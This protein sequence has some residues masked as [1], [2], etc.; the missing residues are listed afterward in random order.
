MLVSTSATVPEAETASG[1]AKVIRKKQTRY[2]WHVVISVGGVA[3]KVGR[4][5]GVDKKIVPLSKTHGR[6]PHDGWLSLCGPAF[7][8]DLWLLDSSMIT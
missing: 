3:Q 6:Y 5:T 2:T 1:W 8:N 7:H 4:P